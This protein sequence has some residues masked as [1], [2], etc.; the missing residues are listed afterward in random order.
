L[1]F[2]N[3]NNTVL[4]GHFGV[5]T[6]SETAKVYPSVGTYQ[7]APP[8][9]RSFNFSSVRK[10]HRVGEMLVRS[11]QL[12]LLFEVGDCVQTGGWVGGSGSLLGKY[13][14]HE[15]E[16][17]RRSRALYLTLYDPAYSSKLAGC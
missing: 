1:E 16:S 11:L 15:K 8:S 3:V 5:T 6:E 12:F 9:I 10:G 13:I 17:M 4:Y 14:T 7:I 2:L